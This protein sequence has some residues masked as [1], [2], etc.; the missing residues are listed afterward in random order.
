M[1]KIKKKFNQLVVFMF[2]S[3]PVISAL[4]NNAPHVHRTIHIIPVMAYLVILGLD[5]V[6]IKI[7]KLFPSSSLINSAGKYPAF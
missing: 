6:Y 5:W 7:T 2:F 1:I 3:Y 4:T